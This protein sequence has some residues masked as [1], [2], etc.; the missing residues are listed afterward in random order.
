V[1]LGGRRLRFGIWLYWL[2]IVVV[3]VVVV[4][5]VVVE[6][7]AVV[8]VVVAVVDDVAVEVNDGVVV[9][10]DVDVVEAVGDDDGVVAVDVD[11]AAPVDDVRL[12]EC[13]SFDGVVEVVAVVAVVVIVELVASVDACWWASVAIGPR[14]TRVGALRRGSGMSTS[15]CDDEDK[16]RSD[17]RSMMIDRKRN[18]KSESIQHK[19]RT[20]LCSIGGAGRRFRVGLARRRR[21]SGD[22]R[23]RRRRGRGCRL[24]ARAT[25]Q[26]SQMDDVACCCVVKTSIH[27]NR[28]TVEHKNGKRKADRLRIR[29]RAVCALAAAR[30]TSRRVGA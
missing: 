23:R 7:V 13:R 9:V 5:V 28:I 27:R 3:G 20:H 30:R 15:A 19:P 8:V 29:R 10:V 17:D 1:L 22:G 6:V 18:Q 24:A 11:V 25:R 12:F 26:Q 2:D 16:R 14:S 21:C 4:V